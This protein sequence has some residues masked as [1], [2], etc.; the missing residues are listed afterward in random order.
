MVLGLALAGIGLF[1]ADNT[2]K[3]NLTQDSVI[4]GQKVKAGDYKIS[5]E[6]GNAV[7]K[8]HGKQT[9]AVPAREESDATKFASNELVYSKD[10]KLVEARF[11]GTHTKIVF[12]GSTPMNAGQ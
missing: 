10:N 6:N 8:E 7:L 4:E 2:F 11:G 12:E 9:I 5:L 3:M 1:A